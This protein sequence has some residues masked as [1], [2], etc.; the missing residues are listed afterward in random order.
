MNAPAPYAPTDA[1]VAP[2]TTLSTGQSLHMDTQVAL[3]SVSSRRNE[4]CGTC[5]ECVGL[6]R[7]G[8]SADPRGGSL[9]H[10]LIAKATS[11][12]VNPTKKKATRQEKVSVNHPAVTEPNRIP[13][14]IPRL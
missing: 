10:R 4:N 3:T 1:M 5:S 2:N 14:G 13:T 12:P 11:N 6:P 8:W 9:I 7:F